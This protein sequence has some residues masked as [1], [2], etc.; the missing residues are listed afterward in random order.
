M[1]L[2]ALIP[3][4]EMI[5][6]RISKWAERRDAI[7]QAEADAKVAVLK[8][9]AELAAYTVKSEIEW[10]LKWADQASNSWKDEWL[11][12]LWTVPLVGLFIPPLRPYVIEGFDYMRGFHEDAGYWYMAGWAIIFAATFGLK[13]A[14]AYMLPGKAAHL[15]KIIGEL[16]DDI[17][18]KAASSAQAAISK[19]LAEKP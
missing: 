2:L 9:K 14:L 16:P 18:D 1:G 5:V 6:D 19:L 4:G 12:I 17:P 8:A 10:D 11:L 13:G 15:A 3:F 7:K